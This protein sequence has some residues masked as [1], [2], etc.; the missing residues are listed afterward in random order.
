M[1]EVWQT[2]E[3]LESESEDEISLI[4][5]DEMCAT[6]KFTSVNGLQIAVA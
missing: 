2:P 4:E 1:T 5:Q 3:K 6:A